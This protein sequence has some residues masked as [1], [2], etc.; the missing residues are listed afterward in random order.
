MRP[1]G[2]ELGTFSSPLADTWTTRDP[3]SLGLGIRHGM[4][5]P[6]GKAGLFGQC[7]QTVG[8]AKEGK[9]SFLLFH[10]MNPGRKKA[11]GQALASFWTPPQSCPVYT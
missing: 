9:T 1:Q 5:E 4:T 8:K 10:P 2:H 6:S 3:C 7:R 11:L